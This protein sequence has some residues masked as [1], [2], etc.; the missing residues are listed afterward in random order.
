VNGRTKFLGSP[1]IKEG[2]LAA[3]V[4]RVLE[5]GEEDGDE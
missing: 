4:S 3:R 1:G 5:E 2:K